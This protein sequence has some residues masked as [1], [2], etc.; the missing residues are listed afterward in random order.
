MI[1]VVSCLSFLYIYVYICYVYMSNGNILCA[2][3]NVRMV[4]VPLKLN[5]FGGLDGPEI[6]MKNKFGGGKCAP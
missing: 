4:N 1:H 3:N 2:L 6:K 5:I